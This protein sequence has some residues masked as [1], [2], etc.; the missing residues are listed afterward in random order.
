[1]ADIG[2]GRGETV[3]IWVPVKDW[4]DNYVTPTSVKVS[5]WDPDGTQ[6]VTEQSAAEDE[7]GRYV[8]YY[9]LATDA[10]LGYWPMKGI[11]TDGTGDAARKTMPRGSF[12][13]RE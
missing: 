8:Y 11:I 5:V 13:V 9:P 2:F 12:L 3:P 6:K 7:T 1:M 4:D 10:M